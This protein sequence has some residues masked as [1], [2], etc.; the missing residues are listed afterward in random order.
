MGRRRGAFTRGK[1][2]QLPPGAGRARACGDQARPQPR[3]ALLRGQ[4]IASPT[5]RAPGPAEGR[6]G[7]RRGLPVAIA[8]MSRAHPNPRLV[9]LCFS[10]ACR[11][12]QRPGGNSHVLEEKEGGGEAD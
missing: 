11:G 2:Q 1:C 10:S 9:V 12:T 8:V 4:G 3:G 7:A 5:W 6:R